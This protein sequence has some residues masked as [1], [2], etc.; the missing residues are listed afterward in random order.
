MEVAVLLGRGLLKAVAQNYGHVEQEVVTPGTLIKATWSHPI[1]VD[2]LTSANAQSK[3]G[4]TVLKWFEVY[5]N[6]RD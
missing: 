5:F 4:D 3:L 2:T 1:E 6:L